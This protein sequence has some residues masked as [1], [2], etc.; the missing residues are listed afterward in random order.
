MK[1][2]H[3]SLNRIT[4]RLLLN[5]V[6]LDK[7]GLLYGKM[8]VVLYFAHLA[9]FT[10]EGL[11]NAYACELIESI[12]KEV[13]I[14]LPIDF[15]T[16]LCG[17]A[18]GLHHLLQEGFMEGS[19]NDVLLDVDAKIMERDLWRVTDLSVET[20]LAGMGYYI[21]DR[22]KGCSRADYPLPFDKDYLA[23]WDAVAHKVADS[24]TISPLDYILSREAP[25]AEKMTEWPLGLSCGAAGVGLKLIY[26]K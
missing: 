2:N 11:Y 13:H 14:S 18:W 19:V 1:N 17:I 10:G 9:R 22:V 7:P 12:Y 21:E 4:N 5:A 23:A 6:F 3:V 8:G 20:G 24:L 16:G 26:E 25:T 15:S